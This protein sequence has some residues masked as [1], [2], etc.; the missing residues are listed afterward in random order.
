MCLLSSYCLKLL[1]SVYVF[2]F[3]FGSEGWK[4][5]ETVMGIGEGIF[6]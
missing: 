3:V 5:L 4:E 2:Y 1:W 6:T